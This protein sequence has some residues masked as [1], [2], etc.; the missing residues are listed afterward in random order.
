MRTI[1]DL[2]NTARQEGYA[3]E[4]TINLLTNHDTV[5]DSRYSDEE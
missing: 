3:F 4:S 2:I 1:Q 5:L